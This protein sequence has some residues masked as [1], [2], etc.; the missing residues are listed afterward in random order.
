MEPKESNSTTKQICKHCGLEIEQIV[1]STIYKGMWVHTSGQWFNCGFAKD[2]SG[3]MGDTIATPEDHS[4]FYPFNPEVEKAKKKAA[5]LQQLA[6]L[7]PLCVVSQEISVSK[8]VQCIESD[9][10]PSR[11]MRL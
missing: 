9:N 5:L 1:D 7:D 10:R 11:K 6:E 2:P 8:S 3:P 4:S